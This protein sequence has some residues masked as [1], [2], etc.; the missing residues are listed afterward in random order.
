[1]SGIG[2]GCYDNRILRYARKRYG[3]RVTI[4]ARIMVQRPQVL[5]KHYYD[6]FV[7]TLKAAI[8]TYHKAEKGV[9]S[10]QGTIQ[11][12]FGNDAIGQ[13][14][15]TMG[16][17][18]PQ[19]DHVHFRD[20]LSTDKS[21]PQVEAVVQMLAEKLAATIEALIKQTG[22]KGTVVCFDLFKLE[23]GT[24]NLE[25][26]YCVKG[27]EPTQD[28]PTGSITGWFAYKLRFAVIPKTT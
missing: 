26:F 23:D 16:T 27:Y 3:N 8:P 18:G 9:M 19:S 14:I 11:M 17:V 2:C 15:I 1:M 12:V 5:N 25:T 21:D 6:L 10:R 28:D 7:R 20:E 22:L 4:S 13:P 24:P